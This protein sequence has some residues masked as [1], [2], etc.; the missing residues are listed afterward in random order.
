VATTAQQGIAFPIT[1]RNN[2]TPAGGGGSD[3][4]MAIRAQVRFV[5][6]NASRLEVAT[7]TASNV[8]P[9][10]AYT[11][12]ARVTAKAN[13]TVPVTA[14]LYTQHGYKI[15]RPI[16]VE[17]HVTQNGTTGWA[18][19]VLAGIVLIAS[20]TWRIRQVSRERATSPAPDEAPINPALTSMPATKLD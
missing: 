1:V 13:G 14:Q 18:I 4:P 11:G 5:S 9:D 17:V 7:V 16:S 20:T 12:N 19:A 2:L 10:R 3:D 8:A 15:G 6:D